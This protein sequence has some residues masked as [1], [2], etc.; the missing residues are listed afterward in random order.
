MK[1]GTILQTSRAQAGLTQRE[2]AVRTGVPQST[3]AR[4][5]RGQTDPRTSTLNTLLIGCGQMLTGSGLSP[6][7]PFGFSERAKRY[8]PT[9]VERIARQFRPAKIVLFGSQV[10]GRARD[11]SDID[12]VVVFEDLANKREMRVAIRKAIADLVVDKDILV[13]TSEEVATRTGGQVLRT[14]IEEGVLLYG[15]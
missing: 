1:S 15:R 4:I 8:L 5:E 2:L 6:A 9:V 3:I 14:A 7:S 12:I 10:R 11:H 13:A